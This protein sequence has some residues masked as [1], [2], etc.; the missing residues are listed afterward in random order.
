MRLPS[1]SLLAQQCVCGQLPYGCSNSVLFWKILL[2]HGFG[3]QVGLRKPRRELTWSHGGRPWD[4]GA[5]VGLYPVP[6]GGATVRH[7]AYHRVFV[8]VHLR[9]RLLERLRGLSV[10]PVDI[11]VCHREARD[12][13][14]S[15][16][17]ASERNQPLC[18]PHTASVAKSMAS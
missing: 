10:V 11:F 9:A 5:G 15:N 14:P 3:G 6:L 12:P 13:R 7:P 17:V 4:V 1:S 18:L 16:D 2:G 8:S